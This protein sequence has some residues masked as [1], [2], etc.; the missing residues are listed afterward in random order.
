[1]KIEFLVVGAL[2]LTGTVTAQPTAKVSSWKKDLLTYIETKL[3]KPDGGYGWED[4]YDSHLTPTYAVTGILYNIGEL[5]KDKGRLAEF[6][7]THHPQKGTNTTS[8]YFLGNAP[9]GEA[10]PSGSNLRNLVYEQIQ[11]ILWLNGDVSSFKA[12]VKSWKSQAGILANYEGHGYGGLFQEAMTPVCSSLLG[13]S[14]DKSEEFLK[15]LEKN[16]RSNGSFNNAPAANGGDGNILNTYWALYS[17]KELSGTERL[18]SE[19]IN[20]LQSCQLANGG[21]THQ[22]NPTIG[23]N[24]DVIYTWA[25]IK[26][27]QMLG[28][29]PKNEKRVIDYLLSLRNADGGFGARLGLH[30][31]PVASFYAIDALKVLNA[32][33]A[34]DKSVKRKE[35]IEPKPDFSGHQV[36]TVQ[37][38]AHGQGS[39]LEAVM[40]ADSLKIHLWGVKY[41]VAGWLEEAQKIA[42]NK[43]VPVTFFMS[44]EPHDNLLSIPG[45][46]SFDHVLDYIAPAKTPIH[47]ADSS[48]FDEFK[49]TTLK[50]LKEANGGMLLQVSNNEPLARLLL[51]ESVNNFGYLAIST[52]HFGQNFMFWLPYI[53]EYRYRLPLVTLQDAHGTE[54]W[55]WSNELVNHRTLFIA[56]EPGYNAMIDALK[57]NWVVG[58]RHDS[59]SNYKTRMLGGTMAA[60]EFITAKQSIWQWWDKDESV[61]RPWAA[62]TLITPADKFEAGHP[63]KGVAIRVRP[64]WNSVRQ[65]LRAPVVALEKLEIDGQTVEPKLITVKARNG[66]VADSYYLYQIDDPAA[67]SHA[68]KATLK[69]LK[70]GASKVINGNW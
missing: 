56:K 35:A 60:R 12:D 6:I 2:F 68:V 3:S 45:M 34:L 55:W 15:Y 54:S 22:P 40:L 17:F 29:R 37:F 32:I 19:T 65:S 66:D 5:P 47:Y 51:D 52:V 61:R 31:T 57:K 24:D 21:F 41:P 59:V 63:D 28:A 16:R 44:D 67:G 20:W 26:S 49:N 1:M 23:V 58:T 39:P 69:N 8:N 36:Y 33:N 14:M 4:Q 70:S 38:Q 18:S 11:A 13:I 62:L 46:G 25:G 27:L 7:R 64:W 9:R 42:Q 30:S 10:G 53:A 43:N 50:N 48:T